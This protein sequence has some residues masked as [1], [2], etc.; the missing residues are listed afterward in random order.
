MAAA[1]IDEWRLERA[2]ILWD[3]KQGKISKRHFQK[4]QDFMQ[5]EWIRIER[6]E[7]PEVT[8][9]PHDNPHRA[10]T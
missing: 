4:A 8:L 1:T 6:E 7:A 9:T 3:F 2:L 10:L 5:Q